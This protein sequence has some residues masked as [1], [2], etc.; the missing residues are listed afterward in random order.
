MMDNETHGVQ[1]SVGVENKHLGLHTERGQ[2]HEP[3]FIDGTVRAK[4]PR[5]LIKKIDKHRDSA[6]HA[7]K[8]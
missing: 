7:R 2:H 5:T 6:V 8:M 3:V 1:C 4:D